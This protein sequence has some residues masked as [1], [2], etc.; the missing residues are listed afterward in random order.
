MATSL[1]QNFQKLDPMTPGSCEYCGKETDPVNA[2]CSLTCE[3]MNRRLES[4]QGLLVIRELKR[5]R[6][7]PN[8]AARNDALSKV[9]PTVDRMLASD[10]KRRERMAAERRAAEEDATKPET[11][12]EPGKAI[13][14]IRRVGTEST[15]DWGE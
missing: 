8:H 6:K 4:A 2:F 7:S 1:R 10:R 12:A 13:E 3:A 15:G 5:W 9:V 14:H 11:T